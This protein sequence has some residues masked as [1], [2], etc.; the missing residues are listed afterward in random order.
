MQ[1]QITGAGRYRQIYDR[2]RRGLGRKRGLGGLGGQRSI[3]GRLV[4]ADTPER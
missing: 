4:L 3:L 1:I 2:H